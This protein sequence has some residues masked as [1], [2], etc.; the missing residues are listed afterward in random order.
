MRFRLVAYN[1]DGESVSDTFNLEGRSVSK[2]E[3]AVL[4]ID[5]RTNSLIEGEE[6][7]FN[8]TVTGC[9]ARIR[10]TRGTSSTVYD[11]EFETSSSSDKTE[12]ITF[13]VPDINS[14]YYFTAYDDDD[15]FDRVKY[16]LTG[17]VEEEIKIKDVEIEDDEV[18]EDDD[19]NITVT[20]SNSASRVWVEDNRGTQVSKIYKSPDD[21]D[22]SDLIWEINFTPL[23]DG[24]QTFTIIAQADHKDDD[25]WDFKIT[26][27]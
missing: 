12:T 1:E 8:V 15:N 11:E 2:S 17:D 22:G 20:T 14:D 27:Y 25:S 5:Q 23:D 13:E 3:P 24:R 21:E 10:V 4:Y 6:A 16:K 7:K 26:V 9:V 19:V 18:D